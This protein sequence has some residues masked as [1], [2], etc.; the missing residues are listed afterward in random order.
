[1]DQDMY[2]ESLSS[3]GFFKLLDLH[4]QRSSIL[5]YLDL[6]AFSVS[7]HPLDSNEKPFDEMEEQI[8][9]KLFSFSPSL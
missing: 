7:G 2:L 6:Q 1:M 3:F 8:K 5:F 9:E 4:N